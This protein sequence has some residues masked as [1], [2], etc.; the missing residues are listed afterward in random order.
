M[1]IVELDASQTAYAAAGTSIQRDFEPTIHSIR[2]TQDHTEVDYSSSSSS[3]LEIDLGNFSLKT[4]PLYL[5]SGLI[6][7]CLLINKLSEIALKIIDTTE[8]VSTI[9]RDPIFMRG[10]TILGAGLIIMAFPTVAFV[11]HSNNARRVAEKG[12]ET[13]VDME[14]PGRAQREMLLEMEK[15]REIATEKDRQW[16]RL[17]LE[18]SSPKVPRMLAITDRPRKKSL[19]KRSIF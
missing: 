1:S 11:Q 19:R 15:L 17:M 13:R 5:L 4:M 6:L 9:V 2:S 18:D 10:V 8:T 16:S 12:F 3:H 7:A 14:M